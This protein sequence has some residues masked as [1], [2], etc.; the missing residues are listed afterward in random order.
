M[1]GQTQISR[2]RIH[3]EGLPLSLVRFGRR[4]GEEVPR[5]RVSPPGMTVLVGG[6]TQRGSLSLWVSPRLCLFLSLFSVHQN[7]INHFWTESLLTGPE[8]LSRV[9]RP[10]GN[11]K[12]S[13]VP[14]L[15]SFSF[16][17]LSP[18]SI[19]QR[20]LDLRFPNLLLQHSRETPIISRAL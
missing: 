3:K 1:G 14:S 7:G 5:Q 20:S 18:S 9:Q 4:W 8:P 6:G 10:S 16:S 15:T 11:R 17:P 13:L 2:L 12:L 19:A